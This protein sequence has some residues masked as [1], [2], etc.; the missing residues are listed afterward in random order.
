MKYIRMCGLAMIVAGCWGMVM[1]ALVKGWA[2]SVAAVAAGFWPVA[3]LM[4]GWAAMVAAGY[5]LVA[6]AKPDGEPEIDEVEARRRARGAS[7]D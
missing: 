5:C 3:W 1:I 6:L 4:I 7:G 2:I